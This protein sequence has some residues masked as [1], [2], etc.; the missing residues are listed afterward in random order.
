MIFY[1][2]LW[3][4][5]DGTPYYAGKGKGDRAFVRKGHNCPPPK[6]KNRI[7]VQEFPDEDSAFR[8]EEFL[9]AL[10]GRKDNGTGILR[11]LTDGG[12][13]PP[14]P[15]KGRKGKPCSAVARMKMSLA[16][17]GVPKSAAHIAAIRA[18]LSEQ[19]RSQGR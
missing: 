9:I 17:K 19:P 10:Y 4:R 2:Y 18:A 1:T 5:E 3:L 7:L 12:D 8:A 11:N 13:K 14:I 16:S 15:K 6:E